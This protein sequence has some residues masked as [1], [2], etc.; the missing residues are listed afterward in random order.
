MNSHLR[1]LLTGLNSTVQSSFKVS[2]LVRAFTSWTEPTHLVWRIQLDSWMQR[3]CCWIPASWNAESGQNL[4][5]RG[6]S[7]NGPQEFFGTIWGLV[8]ESQRDRPRGRCLYYTRTGA[9]FIFR[10][11]AMGNSDTPHLQC[12]D[13]L[14]ICKYA[15]RTRWRD[16]Q[17]EAWMCINIR[18]SRMRYT[19]WGNHSPSC[20]CRPG[21]I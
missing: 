13:M 11:G 15:T 9:Y 16:S 7:S 20:M 6:G 14:A 18:H 8:R 3:S 2:I 19:R 1:P 21:H 10:A 5:T 4:Y 17:S 12:S